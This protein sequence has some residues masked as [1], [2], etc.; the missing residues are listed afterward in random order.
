MAVIDEQFSLDYST[1]R[2]NFYYC[3]SL[4]RINVRILLKIYQIPLSVDRN[5][6]LTFICLKCRNNDSL[7]VYEGGKKFF[8]SFRVFEIGQ[9]IG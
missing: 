7:S 1:M 9:K 4:S 5:C 6:F 8:I 3:P 2:H